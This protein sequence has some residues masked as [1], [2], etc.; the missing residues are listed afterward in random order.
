MTRFQF[1]EFIKNYELYDCVDYIESASICFNWDILLKVME[2][3]DPEIDQWTDRVLLQIHNLT[4]FYEVTAGSYHKSIEIA[5]SD[6]MANVESELVCL[7]DLVMKHQ[8]VLLSEPEIKA[9]NEY[10]Y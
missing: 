6:L 5:E 2:I 4:E 3:E 8:G 10:C 7:E 9:I 1:I